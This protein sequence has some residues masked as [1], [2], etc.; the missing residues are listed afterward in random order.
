[1]KTRIAVVCSVILV[2]LFSLTLITPFGDKKNDSQHQGAKLAKA[3][4]TAWYAWSRMGL[5]AQY[6]ATHDV[7][8]MTR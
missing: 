5:S 3:N 1:M 7:E 8:H 4:I 6:V 2:C